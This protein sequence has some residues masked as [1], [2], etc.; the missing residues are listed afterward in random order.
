MLISSLS[1]WGKILYDEGWSIQH[2]HIEMLFID[3]IE[4]KYHDKEHRAFLK[5][6]F[7]YFRKIN[8]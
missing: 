2:L 4:H 1:Y 8:L 6:L 5:K 7:C 3:Y